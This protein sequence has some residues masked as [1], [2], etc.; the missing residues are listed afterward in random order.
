M[1]K[2]ISLSYFK[3]TKQYNKAEDYGLWI[4]MSATTIFANLPEVL[5][6]YR[7]H[8][9]QTMHQY[10]NVQN[11]IADILRL[12]MLQQTFEILPSFDEMQIHHNISNFLAV[13]FFILEQWLAKLSYANE[14]KSF[15]NQQCFDLFLGKIILQQVGIQKLKIGHIVL[16]MLK[17]NMKKS[18][19][20]AL[21][22]YLKSRLS[23]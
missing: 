11:N 1:I 19:L 16:Y 20:K 10:S 6:M 21:F 3:Y 2:A 17:S 14:T 13:D 22:Y 4:E 7:C 12:K 8:Q 5:L 9:N 15:L 23:G 18:I